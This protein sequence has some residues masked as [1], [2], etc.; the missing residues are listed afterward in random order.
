MASWQLASKHWAEGPAEGLHTS[1]GRHRGSR[2]GSH[3][4]SQSVHT[5][6]LAA[7]LRTVP[8]WGLQDTSRRRPLCA[9]PTAS[10]WGLRAAPALL[11]VRPQPL[12]SPSPGVFTRASGAQAPERQWCLLASCLSQEQSLGSG[13]LDQDRTRAS[14]PNQRQ[15]DNRRT[16]RPPTPPPSTF[17]SFPC[18]LCSGLP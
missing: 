9:A 4:A 2:R 3:A 15:T 8:V 18:F 17:H 10:S 14:W 11:S 1:G 5:P 13:Q 12:I 6:A 7:I 16:D